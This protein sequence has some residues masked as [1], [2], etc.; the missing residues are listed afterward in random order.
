MGIICWWAFNVLLLGG[1][2]PG[3]QE[4]QQQN[5]RQTEQGFTGQGVDQI[6]RGVLQLGRQVPGQDRA[7]AKFAEEHQ[8]QEPGHDKAVLPKA[9]IAQP[10]PQGGGHEKA[11]DRTDPV[12]QQ[13]N[14]GI[15][16]DPTKQLRHRL[17][18][19]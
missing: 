10:A 6:A 1:R 7:E 17:G 13:Q 15:L 18:P 19:G 3:G 9:G 11:K 5:G 2:Y 8:A 12:D 4:Q 16:A 14:S